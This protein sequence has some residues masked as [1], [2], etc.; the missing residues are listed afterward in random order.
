MIRDHS[1]HGRSKF[2][3]SFGLP[4]SKWSGT[5]DPSKSLSSQRST[6]PKWHRFLSKQFIGQTPLHHI[7]KFSFH[8]NLVIHKQPD[9]VR[10]PISY[11]LYLPQVS[12]RIS[13]NV[14]GKHQ[15]R[16]CRAVIPTSVE[17]QSVWE[18]T[19]DACWVSNEESPISVA[20]PCMTDCVLHN[21]LSV[22]SHKSSLSAAQRAVKFL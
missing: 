12:S 11:K 22:C 6:H 2:I 10:N 14:W 3:G 20:S 1:D 21:L 15:G 16:S 9:T 19:E 7:H 5:S 13:G 18:L 8:W 17:E 4:W